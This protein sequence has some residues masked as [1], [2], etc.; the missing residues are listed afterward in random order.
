M[1]MKSVPAPIDAVDI[2]V[3][4]SFPPQYMLHV[5]SGL[6]SG[7]ARFERYVVDRKGDTIEVTVTNL[8]PADENVVCTAIYG[9]VES[10]IPLGSDFQSGKTYTVKVNDVIKTFVAQ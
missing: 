4:E 5:V 1:R 2:R 3:M 9:Q 8:V 7:C 10:N 6:P